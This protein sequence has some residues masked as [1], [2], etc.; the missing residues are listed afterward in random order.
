VREN[1]SSDELTPFD[2]T[3]KRISA[4]LEVLN[5]KIYKKKHLE[6]TH[7]KKLTRDCSYHLQFFSLTNLPKWRIFTKKKKHLM[8][9]AK[10]V[11]ITMTP[12]STKN[13]DTNPTIFS[14]N[15]SAVNIYTPKL[16]S[17][18][19]LETKIFSSTSKKRFR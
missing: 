15:P 5:H 17:L 16:C 19:R 4:A 3:L 12:I 14:Y 6:L 8:K 7:L 1:P 11:I 18:V 2:R 9:I 13:P 10:I